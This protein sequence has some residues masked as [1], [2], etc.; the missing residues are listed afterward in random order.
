MDDRTWHGHVMPIMSIDVFRLFLLEAQIT[1][2]LWIKCNLKIKI[3]S[4]G[5]IFIKKIEWILWINAVVLCLVDQ[6][7]MS[8]G[9]V[10]NLAIINRSS[11]VVPSA[12]PAC[13]V[14]IP[15]R[16]DYLTEKSLVAIWPIFHQY[17]PTDH[18]RIAS[19]YWSPYFLAFR[20]FFVQAIC[21]YKDGSNR[22]QPLKS[23]FLWQNLRFAQKR[24]ATRM[25][26]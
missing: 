9:R 20:Y 26:C 3:F 16:L 12:F 17:S 8:I 1:L 23:K 6:R 11:Q 10:L 14:S 21:E 25:G 4:L 5:F 19:C 18:C 15:T 22:D 24:V 13:C 7:Q 2:L